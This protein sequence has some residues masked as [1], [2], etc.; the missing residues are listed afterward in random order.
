MRLG[1]SA[2]AALLV[3]GLLAA[4]AP[5]ARADILTTQG[6]RCAGRISAGVALDANAA[7]RAT[8]TAKS[9]RTTVAS[10][11]VRLS[12]GRTTVVLCLN[13]AGRKRLRTGASSLPALLSV[14]ATSGTSRTTATATIRFRRR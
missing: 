11:K 14:A 1:P 5:P 7:G 8:I 13:S 4:A 6:R 12:S 3:V 2:I 9:G 10:K